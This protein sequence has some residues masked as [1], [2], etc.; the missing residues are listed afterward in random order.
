M[1]NAAC[2]ALGALTFCSSFKLI[3]DPVIT[4]ATNFRGELCTQMVEVGNSPVE[5]DSDPAAALKALASAPDEFL[6]AVLRAQREGTALP[7]APESAQIK[8]RFWFSLEQ[9]RRPPLQGCWLLK[10]MLP[11]K[12]SVFQELN[13]GGE[14]FEGDDPGE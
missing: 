9:E 3:G 7:E 10:E 1:E 4:P 2:A 6:D 12:K 14:E 5:D 11:I 13:E 8:S